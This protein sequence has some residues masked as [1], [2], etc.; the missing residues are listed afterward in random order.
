VDIDRRRYAHAI[1]AAPA[2]GRV[3]VVTQTVVTRPGGVPRDGAG[4]A[5]ATA[6]GAKEAL[7]EVRRRLDLSTVDIVTFAAPEAPGY[8]VTHRG[9][10][11]PDEYLADIGRL[12]SR[13]VTDAPSGD[14]VVEPPLNRHMIGINE[15]L[16]SVRWTHGVGGSR[17]SDRAG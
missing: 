2:R 8:S 5:F 1:E 12:D 9:N 11:A 7:S 14:L 3:R 4:V 10:R 16:D 13:L 17:R 15:A 6:M